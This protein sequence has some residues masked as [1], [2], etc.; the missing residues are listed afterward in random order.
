MSP[1]RHR[2]SK[3]EMR[4]FKNQVKSKQVSFRDFIRFINFTCVHFACMYAHV[5]YTIY[6]MTRTHGG[7]TNASDPW[8]CS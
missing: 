6:H 1:E 8:N 4:I 2:L 7:Q 5:P 3:K